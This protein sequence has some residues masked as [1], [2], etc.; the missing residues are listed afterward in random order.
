[1]YFAFN[2][3]PTNLD[4]TLEQAIED[5]RVIEWTAKEV[6]GE[7]TIPEDIYSTINEITSFKV[8]KFIRNNSSDLADVTA[9]II[10]VGR[11]RLNYTL[12]DPVR[13]AKVLGALRKKYIE[14]DD[15]R[16]RA[17]AEEMGIFATILYTIKKCITWVYL[18][19][20]D[21]KDD[22]KDAVNNKPEGYS[23]AKRYYKDLHNHTF[24]YLA[25]DATYLISPDEDIILPPEPR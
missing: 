10:N 9:N 12:S 13:A 22:F 21:L 23:R 20:L 4:I 5:N 2:E 18:K 24:N 1:M 7:D 19:I 11:A 16:K 3:Q 17:R 25:P 15:K 8:E 14:I 6:L